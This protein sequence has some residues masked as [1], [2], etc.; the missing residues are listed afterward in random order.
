MSK[1]S[2]AIQKQIDQ[3]K[4]WLTNGLTREEICKQF[5]KTFKNFQF[6]DRT[7]D[8]RIK[9]AKLQA[10][11]ILDKSSKMIDSKI[12]EREIEAQERLKKAHINAQE[13]LAGGIEDFIKIVEEQKKAGNS[14][15]I[16]SAQKT[17]KQSGL[18]LKDWLAMLRLERG[19]P[20][21][22]SQN[23]HT[24]KG[25]SLNKQINLDKLSDSE[26]QKL[27]TL[28]KKTENE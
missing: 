5:S 10:Q 25:E 7:V 27:E 19:Q 16:F 17:A 9:Q 28:L 24:T 21:T 1:T 2:P 18:D 13:I 15:A 23:D 4:I 6:T 8:N 3:V 26:L 12:L 14:L 11:P 20:N 22:I